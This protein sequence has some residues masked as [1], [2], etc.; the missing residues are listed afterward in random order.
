MLFGGRPATALAGGSFLS[1]LIVTSPWSSLEACNKGTSGGLVLG[2]LEGWGGQGGG[3][4]IVPWC[5][6]EARIHW[7]KKHRP[8]SPQHFSSWCTRLKLTVFY[9]YIYTEMCLKFIFRIRPQ[10]W[11]VSGWRD[12]SRISYETFK[13]FNIKCVGK[14]LDLHWL[15][16]CCSVCEYDIISE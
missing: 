15:Q 4:Q 11:L 7:Q 12:K 6:P 3:E 16:N 5:F 2:R 14:S 8:I 13:T 9:G 10:W 1:L